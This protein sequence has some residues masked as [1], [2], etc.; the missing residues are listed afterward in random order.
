MISSMFTYAAVVT[1]L[2]VGVVMALTSGG[3]F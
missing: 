3:T 2:A 1:F